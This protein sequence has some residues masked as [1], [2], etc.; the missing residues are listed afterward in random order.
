MPDPYI[1]SV[2]IIAALIGGAAMVAVWQAGFNAGMNEAQ[3]RGEES[4]TN[5]KHVDAFNYHNP[6]NGA[7]APGKE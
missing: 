5:R 2:F 3:R 6:T 1:A 4:R 7:E